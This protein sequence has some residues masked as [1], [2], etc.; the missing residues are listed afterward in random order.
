MDYITTKYGCRI[1]PLDTERK[2]IDP[3]LE[4]IANNTYLGISN[5]VEGALHLQDYHKEY[6]SRDWWSPT[7]VYNEFLQARYSAPR[8]C[9][10]TT[11]TLAC[12]YKYKKLGFKVHYI[13]PKINMKESLR[14]LYPELYDDMRV[15]PSDYMMSRLF[16]RGTDDNFDTIIFHDT[17]NVFENSSNANVRDMYKS[18]VISKIARIRLHGKKALHVKIQ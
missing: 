2:E 8:Q 15:V 7:A 18:E 12:A 11:G 5:L 17:Y 10:S 14:N 4:N 9:G 6:L 16:P 1:C 13:V 3:L